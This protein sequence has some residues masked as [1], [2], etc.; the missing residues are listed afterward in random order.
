M[1]PPSLEPHR[2]R[3]GRCVPELEVVGESLRQSRV[4]LDDENPA[5]RRTNSVGAWQAG[6]DTMNRLPM[7]N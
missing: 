6:N 3:Y 7:E 5:H 4:V 2:A 1:P